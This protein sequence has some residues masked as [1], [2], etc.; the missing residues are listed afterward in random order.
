M[1][2]LDKKAPQFSRDNENY[3][4]QFRKGLVNNVLVNGV[5]GFFDKKA[6]YDEG[7]STDLDVYTNPI[8]RGNE[9]SI[10]YIGI[11]LDA[12]KAATE[13]LVCRSIN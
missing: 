3:A 6:F 11:N 8:L 1:F 4:R 12:N 9:V 10:D 5:W 13:I 7:V 2:I